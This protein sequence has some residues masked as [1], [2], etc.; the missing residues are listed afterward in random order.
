M[1]T[2]PDNRQTSIRPIKNAKTVRF[3]RPMVIPFFS[4]YVLRSKILLHDVQP[5]SYPKSAFKKASEKI[6]DDLWMKNAQFK[7]EVLPESLRVL[8]EYMM[9]ILYSVSSLFSDS[10]DN[11]GHVFNN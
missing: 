6:V 4:Q 5:K 9:N 3:G 11:F 1:V 7:S 2:S 10:S 8:S